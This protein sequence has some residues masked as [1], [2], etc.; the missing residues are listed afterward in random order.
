MQSV[1]HSQGASIIFLNH[2]QIKNPEI[3]VVRALLSLRNL[4]YVVM[5]SIGIDHFLHL[6]SQTVWDY[7]PLFANGF[8]SPAK[9][10]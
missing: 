9:K 4:N 5:A 2:K 1:P 7:H 10:C 3:K 6:C 8:C